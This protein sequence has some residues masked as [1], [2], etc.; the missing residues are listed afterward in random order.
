LNKLTDK[1]YDT[2]TV[3]IK[4]ILDEF[5]STATVATESDELLFKI[6]RVIIEIASTN[7]FYSKIY[8][9]VYVFILHNYPSMTTIFKECCADYL[10]IFDNIEYTDSNE[11]Y[12]KF[13]EMNKTNERRKSLSTFLYNLMRNGAL[14][15]AELF[16]IIVPLF[17]NILTNIAAASSSVQKIN[18]IDEMVENFVMLYDGVD[19][20]DSFNL[21]EEEGS[22]NQILCRIVKLP[23]TFKGLS[24]KTKFKFME[25]ME[26]NKIVCA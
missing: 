17:Q 1:N 25:F 19:N 5:I 16:Q 20:G 13:C 23:K 11:N 4:E 18:E 12:D 6:G 10:K 26:K 22:M 15:R 21:F 7:R 9:D 8:A 3:K 14:P 2:T 24:M